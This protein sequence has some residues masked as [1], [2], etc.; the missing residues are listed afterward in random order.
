MPA[1][2]PGCAGPGYDDCYHG[3]RVLVYLWYTPH[4]DLSTMLVIFQACTLRSG[5]LGAEGLDQGFWFIFA[6]GSP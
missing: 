5:G 3:P 6:R 4:M 1:L 2:P